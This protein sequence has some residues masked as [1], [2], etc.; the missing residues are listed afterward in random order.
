MLYCTVDVGLV[1]PW[2]HH[3]FRLQLRSEFGVSRT[4]NMNGGFPD[5]GVMVTSVHL[6]IFNSNTKKKQYPNYLINKPILWHWSTRHGS[7]N[8]ESCGRCHVLAGRGW[9]GRVLNDRVHCLA[10]TSEPIFVK[11]WY[12]WVDSDVS[13]GLFSFQFTMHIWYCTKLLEAKSG[14]L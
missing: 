5:F 7:L 13:W 14:S 4:V 10:S 12:R 8:L 3:E 2:G 6:N 9:C 1:K 11:L